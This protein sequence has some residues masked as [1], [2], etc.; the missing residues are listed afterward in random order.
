M[1]YPARVSV[2]FTDVT[3]DGVVDTQVLQE[4][5]VSSKDRLRKVSFAEQGKKERTHQLIEALHEV[6]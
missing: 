2:R 4:S 6:D 5:L 1:G 3:T